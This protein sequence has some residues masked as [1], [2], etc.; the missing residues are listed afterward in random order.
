MQEVVRAGNPLD[1]THT[2]TH[3]HTLCNH[4]S[5]LELFARNW[6]V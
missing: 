1:S 4:L 6:C 3:T 5:I 2:H